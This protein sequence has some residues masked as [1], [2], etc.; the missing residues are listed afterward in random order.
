MLMRLF[1]NERLACTRARY[2]A[3]SLPDGVSGEPQDLPKRPFGMIFTRVF[4]TAVFCDFFMELL[5]L[6]HFLVFFL[7]LLKSMVNTM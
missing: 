1:T 5:R 6:V 7:Q 4:G 3:C 2:F